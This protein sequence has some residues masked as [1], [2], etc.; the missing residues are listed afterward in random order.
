MAREIDKVFYGEEKIQIASGYISKTNILFETEGIIA[1]IEAKGSVK[2]YDTDENLLDEG[3]V[4]AQTGGREVYEEI[5]PKL[6]GK[7]ITLSFP[8]Y[9]WIDNYPNCDG[10]HDRWS[11][12][13]IGY[14]SLTFDLLEKKVKK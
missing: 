7:S 1:E 6:D 12:K 8:V 3:S 5:Y 9:E 14:E 11:T 13:T 10:E 4:P 2:F